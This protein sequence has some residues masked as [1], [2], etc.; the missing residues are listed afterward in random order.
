MAS[1]RIAAGLTTLAAALL[2]AVPAPANAQPSKTTRVLVGF[3]A[4]QT[5]DIVARVVA[6][7]L[8]QSLGHPVIVENRPGQG[9]SLA[10]GLL[11]KSPPDGSVMTI[12]AL[13]AYVANPHLYKSV[14]YDTLKD[15]DPVALILDIPLVLVTHPSVPA[16]NVAELVAHVKANPGKLSHSSSGNGTIS[17]LAMEDFKRRAG[18]NILH[19]PYQGSG[20]A[21]LDLMAGNVQ[22]AMD[23][24]AVTQMHIQAGKMKLL[25]VGTSKRMAAYA[26]TPTVAELGYPGFEAVA[27]VGAA[28]PAG[29]PRELRERLSSEIVRIVRSPEFEQRMVALGMVTRPAPAPEFAAFLKSEH[30]RWGRIVRE[31]GARVE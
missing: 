17:H 30:E 25:A 27:W 23:A 5:T 6:E 16:A 31:S 4:G 7:R 19:V 15:F 20:K 18:L 26:D 12:S 3:P 11:A 2:L 10:L 1:H 8:T 22:V 24:L 28:L 14:A 13:A 21:M 29:S 9:G